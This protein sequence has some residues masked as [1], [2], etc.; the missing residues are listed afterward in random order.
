M[1]FEDINLVQQFVKMDNTCC[2]YEVW[3]SMDK[4]GRDPT[5]DTEE[6]DLTGQIEL[7]NEKLINWGHF[8]FFRYH[9]SNHASLKMR[10]IVF[11][12]CAMISL[13]ILKRLCG[14]HLRCRQIFILQLFES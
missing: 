4:D 13:H 2:R 3:P 7:M 6:V 12:T 14:N 8:F 5:R 1:P 11:Y 9:N 10:T